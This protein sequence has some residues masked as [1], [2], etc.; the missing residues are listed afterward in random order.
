MSTP[1]DRGQLLGLMRSYMIFDVAGEMEHMLPA[2]GELAAVTIE[3]DT[4]DERWH[5]AGVRARLVAEW[6]RDKPVAEAAK[7]V[8][9]WCFDAWALQLA[10]PV[11]NVNSAHG[12]ILIVSA[13]RP[14]T[15]IYRQLFHPIADAG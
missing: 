15:I 6:D 7:P 13:D 10:E 12:Y 9:P 4:K 11:P 14:C 8:Y 3:I 5:L 1:F 2:C